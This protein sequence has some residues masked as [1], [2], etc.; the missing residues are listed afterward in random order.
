[1]KIGAREIGPGHPPFIIAE[2]GANH[3]GDLK[4][5]LYMM[6]AAKAF[7]ADCVKFQAYEA[8]TITLDHGGPGFRI[9]DGPWAGHRLY[10]LYRKCQTPFGWF[11]KIAE[12]ARHIG[13]TWFASAFDNTAVDL[14]VELDAPAIKIASFEI[15]DLPLIRHAAATGK[16]IILSTG[17]ASN[18][19]ISDANWAIGPRW[20]HD[21]AFLHC[22]SGYPTPAHEANL[23]RLREFCSW[24]YPAGLS[25]HTTGTDI[26]IAATALG[27]CLIEKH[28]TLP[29]LVTEDS[30]FSLEPA[31]FAQMVR[32]VRSTWAALQPSRAASEQSSRPLRRSLYAVADIAAGEEFSTT[33]VRSIR[34]GHGL[35]PKEIDRLLGRTATRDVARGTPLASDMVAE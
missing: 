24:G 1:M 15:V 35:P 8:D 19:E 25:D 30:A 10:D 4:R 3:G 21:V 20:R 17:M 13:V 18:E 33:N 32:A 28:F 22:V 27:A 34:P 7:G 16:P 12:H 29:G 23:G 31:E 2:I 26:P 5:A 14:L 11:P 9:E 6:E